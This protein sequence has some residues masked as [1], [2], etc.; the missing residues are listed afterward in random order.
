[1][2]VFNMFLGEF[3]NYTDN[4]FLNEGQTIHCLDILL[5]PVTVV[6]K[7]SWKSESCLENVIVLLQ[8]TTSLC[9]TK[10]C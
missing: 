2:I 1:M 7:I 9:E 4:L 8:L 6:I 3:E 10:I 5:I